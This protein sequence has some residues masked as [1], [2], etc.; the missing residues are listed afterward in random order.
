MQRLSFQ[1]QRPRILHL[2]PEFQAGAP[3]AL[4]IDLAKKLTEYY[5]VLLTNRPPAAVGQYQDELC[6]KLNLDV[7]YTFK[8]VITR[9]DIVACRPDVIILYDVRGADLQDPDDLQDVGTIYYAH[10]RN[11]VEVSQWSESILYGTMDTFDASPGVTDQNHFYYPPYVDHKLVIDTANKPYPLTRKR[12]V[13]ILGGRPETYDF[14]FAASFINGI[15]RKRVAVI[16]PSFLGVN[17]IFDRAVATGQA[18][19]SIFLCPHVHGATFNAY[20]RA[21]TLVSTGAFRIDTECGVLRRPV[22]KQP[23]SVEEAIETVEKSLVNRR[24]VDELI[25]YG[26]LVAAQRQLDLHLHKFS[27]LVRRLY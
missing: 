22:I 13:A 12:V 21:Q 25:D 9:G 5:H 18:D 20:R 26:R 17:K 14:E 23:D 8:P 15:D 3:L 11:D 27:N 16:I 2:L 24:F 10:Y 1:N 4:A 6:T 19:H 7:R